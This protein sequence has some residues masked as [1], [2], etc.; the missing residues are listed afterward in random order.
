MMARLVF[1]GFVFCLFGRGTAQRSLEEFHHQ[2]NHLAEP[3][4]AS[5]NLQTSAV[6]SSENSRIPVSEK[7]SDSAVLRSLKKKQ[8]LLNPSDAA[9]QYEVSRP[10]SGLPESMYLEVQDSSGPPENYLPPKCS[11]TY[12]NEPAPN[13]GYT[14]YDGSAAYCASN[15]DCRS[16]T[17]WLKSDAPT[18]CQSATC[19]CTDP[20]ERDPNNKYTCNDGTSAYCESSEVCASTDP[21]PKGY[22]GTI[23]RSPTSTGPLVSALQTKSVLQAR[24]LIGIRLP[25]AIFVPMSR[26]IASITIKISHIIGQ[27]D[28]QDA[29]DYCGAANSG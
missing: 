25:Y 26:A 19:S 6:G 11:C 13:N 22:A 1:S 17:T 27:F 18:V 28:K 14:C 9:H 7:R 10:Q 15:Q 29:S 21:W 5:S 23:C 24:I 16:N 4:D 2:L 12:P 3:K 20:N 8:Q